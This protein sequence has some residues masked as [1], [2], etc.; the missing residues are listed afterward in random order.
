[1]LLFSYILFSFCSCYK[2]KFLKCYAKK[3]P[4]LK[5]KK[6]RRTMDNTE[7]TNRKLA[8]HKIKP[9]GFQNNH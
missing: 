1:M 8:F 6:T 5:T 3:L 7:A 9:L 4:W 2:I